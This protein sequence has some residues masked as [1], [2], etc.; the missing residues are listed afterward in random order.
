MFKIGDKV[1][2]E[3][4]VRAAAWCNKN[5]ATIEHIDDK[6]VIVAIQGLSDKE[7]K[8]NEIRQLKEKLAASDYAIIKIA[9]GVA[10]VEEYADLILQ[11]GQWRTKINEL[12]AI[13]E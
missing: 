10:T 5:H 11:R 8:L 4:S 7:L 13:F 2:D 12:E 6:Y 1:T 9:E 3:N